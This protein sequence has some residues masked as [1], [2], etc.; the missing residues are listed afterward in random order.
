M[1]RRAAVLIAAALVGLGMLA[2][3]AMARTGSLN[4]PARHRSTTAPLIR[5]GSTLPGL[6]PLARRM[7]SQSSNWAGY[8]ATGGGF[9]RVSAT[10]TQPA[11]IPDAT[12]ASY[13]AFWVGLDGDGSDSVEQCGTDA[14][15]DHGTPSYYA[16]YEMYPADSV[17]IPMT[18][19]PGDV[20]HGSVVSDGAGNFTLTLSDQTTGVT[21]TFQKHSTITPTNLDRSAEVIAEAPS[22]NNGVLPLAAFGSVSFSSCAIN[23]APLA[24][25][26]WEQIDMVDTSTGTTLATTSALG[27]DGASFWVTQGAAPPP[28]SPTLSGFSPAS[29]PAGT[30]VTLSGTGL[31]GASAVTFAG[32]AA[33]FTVVSDTQITATVPAGATSGA[34]GVT[35][36]GG[37]AT[38]ATAYT[39][40]PSV[41]PL[42]P[43]LG[44]SLSGTR[45]GVLRLGAR[46][47]MR[48]HVTP[49]S[50]AGGHVTLT[51]ERRRAGVWHITFART[52]VIGAD[53]R[54]STSS[55]P[56]GRGTYRVR[57]T[58]AQTAANT[59]AA[60]RWLQFQVK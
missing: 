42:Q 35:T 18:I 32:T 20:M 4:L 19:T 49:S 31:D 27:A 40:T 48:A 16:W 34:I 28:A 36:A 47:T 46:V 22:D 15:N 2:P 1:N 50:L 43:T 13:S 6:G 11:V 17:V 12:T 58:I 39:V 9:S 55:R 29:G 26:A 38:S 8:D 56:G 3:A 10:W 5:V 54:S 57:A 33:R 60:S 24:S 23:G 7:A 25:A 53:G 41:T 37:T 14:D 21:K 45:R 59:A 52:R 51:L 44:L 30:L